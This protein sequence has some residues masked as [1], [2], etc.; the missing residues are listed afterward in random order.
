M[1][2]ILVAMLSLKNAFSDPTLLHGKPIH[3]L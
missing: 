2:S 3:I 1:W